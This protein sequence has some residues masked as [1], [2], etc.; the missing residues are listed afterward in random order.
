MI[1]FQEQNSLIP[2]NYNTYVYTDFSFI[3]HLHHDFEWIYVKEGT[4]ELTVENRTELLH[5]GESA[6]ILQNQIHSFHTPQHSVIWVCVFAKDYVPEFCKMIRDRICKNN[7]LYLPSSD[8]DFL[9][10]KLIE[11]DADRLETCACLHLVCACFMKN[12]SDE[13]FVL[14]DYTGSQLLLHQML[15]HISAHFTENITLHEMAQALGYDESYISRSF[16]AFFKKNFKQFVN[17]YRIHYARE[18][19]AQYGRDKTMTEIAYMSGFQ[20]VRNF[21]RAYRNIVGSQ[22]RDVM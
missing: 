17:E 6:L 21:N 15:V 8:R 13:D 20:S 11:T 7:R 3:P 9:L 1:L 2:Y 14:A 4:L 12:R 19:L 5:T 10:R 16:H 22:P 18:L